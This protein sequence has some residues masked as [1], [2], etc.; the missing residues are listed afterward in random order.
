MIANLGIGYLSPPVGLNR[1]VATAEFKESFGTVVRSVVPFIL[2]MLAAASAA[3]QVDRVKALGIFP[4]MLP[5]HTFY[6][7][8]WH[9]D[10]VFGPERAANISP[11]GWLGKLADFAILSDNPLTAPHESLV[12]L[13]VLET[14]KAVVL[15]VLSARAAGARIVATHLRAEAAEWRLLVGVG[16]GRRL[17]HRQRDRLGI[18]IG[19]AAFG[20]PEPAAAAGFRRSSSR[21]AERDVRVATASPGAPQDSHPA[22]SRSPGAPAPRA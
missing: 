22:V 11:T 20:G 15:L 10:S 19:P 2:I 14:V 1:I 12:E 3:G 9:R 17:L 16:G 7:G 18:R 5:I 8:D 13:K 4:S 6:Q 21:A